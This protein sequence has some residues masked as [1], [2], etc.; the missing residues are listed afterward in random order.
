M[1]LTLIAVAPGTRMTLT[2]CKS[3]QRSSVSDLCLEEPVSALQN[4]DPLKRRQTA[5]A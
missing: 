2:A 4:P 5:K 1:P 3:P